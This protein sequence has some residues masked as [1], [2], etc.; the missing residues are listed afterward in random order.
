[1][2]SSLPTIPVMWLSN[3][4]T[5][6][7]NKTER[8]FNEWMS[9]Y[10]FLIFVKPLFVCTV[11]Q[12]K[13]FSFVVLSSKGSRRNQ[14]FQPFDIRLERIVS[15]K[16]EKLFPLTKIKYRRE[17]GIKIILSSTTCDTKLELKWLPAGGFRYELWATKI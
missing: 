11:V 5:F 9:E 13:R 17:I 12:N 3:T 1:M 4:T 7:W 2:T 8:S 6:T 10:L 14:Y 16:R 15:W